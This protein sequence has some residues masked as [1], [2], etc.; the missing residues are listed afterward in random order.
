MYLL[1]YQV[2]WYSH[3]KIEKSESALILKKFVI[4]GL[5]EPTKCISWMRCIPIY[6]FPQKAAKI[7]WHLLSEMPRG[8]SVFIFKDLNIEYQ[9]R[10]A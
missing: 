7:K 8:F 2:A 3:A 5:L 9:L 4:L 1:K 6:V 10:Q